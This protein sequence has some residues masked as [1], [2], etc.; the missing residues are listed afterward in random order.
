MV[1]VLPVRTHDVQ[2]Q[3]VMSRLAFIAL[4]ESVR[5]ACGQ[6]AQAVQLKKCA[7]GIR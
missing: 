7:G 6:R 4:G 3:T 1:I 2:G 5:A